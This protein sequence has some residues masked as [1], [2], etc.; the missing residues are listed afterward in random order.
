MLQMFQIWL[1]DSELSL[2]F[3][4]LEIPQTKKID[5]LQSLRTLH[6]SGING[7]SKQVYGL[8]PKQKDWRIGF[9]NKLE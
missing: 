9:Q 4:I 8:V 2:K 1:H 3:P 6:D 5:R 7:S